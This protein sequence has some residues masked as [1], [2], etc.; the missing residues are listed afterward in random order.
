MVGGVGL[1]RNKIV[2]DDGEFVVVD[3]DDKGGVGFVV[4]EMEMVF[5]VRGELCYV[6][7]FNVFW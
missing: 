7:G 3:G 6:V 4:D 2:G 5:F 1:D